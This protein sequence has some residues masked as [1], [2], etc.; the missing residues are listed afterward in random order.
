MLSEL[1]TA[2]GIKARQPDRPVHHPRFARWQAP[3]RVD[4]AWNAIG[5]KDEEC[6]VPSPDPPFGEGSTVFERQILF[7]IVPASD[8]TSE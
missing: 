4:S 1:E 6:R 7:E 2:K 5:G 3:L 8:A